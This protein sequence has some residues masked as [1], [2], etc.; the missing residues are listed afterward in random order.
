MLVPRKAVRRVELNL[1]A[2]SM[3][4]TLEPNTTADFS[5]P[6][7]DF[8]YP[9]TEWSPCDGELPQRGSGRPLAVLY[10]VLFVFG[11][12]GNS[13]V[14]LVLVACRKLTSPTDV[15]LLNLALSDLLFVLSFPFQ[16]H[17]RL[18]QWVFGTAMCKVVSG[19]YYVG[20][21]SSMFFITVLSV[22]R[23]LAVVH[24]VYAMKVR[25]ARRGAALSLA[26][27]LAA[28]AATSPL[29]V[30]YQVASED[31]VLQCYSFYDHQTVRWKIFTHLEMNILGLLLPFSILLFCYVGV[32]LQ[33][34][35]CHNRS[36][37][38]AVR[39]VLAVVVASL[40]CWLPFNGVLFLTSLHSMHVLDGCATSQR[41]VSATHV[42]ETISFTHCCVNPVI[43]AFMG[44][45]FKKH[46]LEVFQK[47]CS[48]ICKGRRGPG[49][50][51][52]VSSR[53][54]S[55]DYVL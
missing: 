20:F 2:V 22:D 47:T 28:V 34:K 15:Y 49:E 51:R 36:K 41:L 35:R 5:Y 26:V 31:G 50:V 4:P 55:V 25:T 32:L 16:T 1:S 42:T 43:Y 52:D 10:C 45:K 30:F 18:D 11:L 54:S 27:W 37:A 40:L 6:T 23:Y 24:A 3:D 39:L 8:Y 9:G 17:Y 33:L 7:G 14:I 38:R 53:S 29:L 44:E 21:F 12:L 13:L 19:L 48:Y 46:L